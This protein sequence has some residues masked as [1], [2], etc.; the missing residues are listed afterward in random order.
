MKLGPL[1]AASTTCRP[2]PTGLC[3]V[4]LS[5]PLVDFDKIADVMDVE[6]TSAGSTTFQNAGRIGNIKSLIMPIIKTISADQTQFTGSNLVFDAMSAGS[7]GKKIQLTCSLG[8]DCY[9]GGFSGTDEGYLYFRPKSGR[10]IPFIQRSDSGF[11]PVAAHHPHPGTLGGIP[12]SPLPALGTSGNVTAQSL[13]PPG[14]SS[15][16]TSPTVHAFAVQ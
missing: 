3:D 4:D 9:I 2:E 7:N 10:P 8:S 16:G 11:I 6:L 13:L 14:S 15:N 5:I 1:P 12:S